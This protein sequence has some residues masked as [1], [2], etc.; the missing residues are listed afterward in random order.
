MSPQAVES[1]KVS[2]SANTLRSKARY[3]CSRLPDL[4]TQHQKPNCPQPPRRWTH[5]RSTQ[6]LCRRGR[7][8]EECRRSLRK[9]E[10]RRRWVE[11]YS[12]RRAVL[13]RSPCS[14]NLDDELVVAAAVIDFGKPRSRGV[15]PEWCLLADCHS[16]RIDQLGICHLGL[17]DPSDTRL[18]WM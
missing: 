10:V 2:I 7:Q 11:R 6:K 4:C 13:G 8:N 9:R 16:P 15:D 17:T 14:R 1:T 18:D 3:R 12:C 5:L